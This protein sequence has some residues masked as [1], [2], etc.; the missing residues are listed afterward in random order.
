MEN[1]A[2]DSF[3]T[4]YDLVIPIEETDQ[5]ASSGPHDNANG[6]ED[7][8]SGMHDKSP[9][10]A[11]SMNLNQKRVQL[12]NTNREMPKTISAQKR[13]SLLGE[14]PDDAKY[15]PVSCLNSFT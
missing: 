2:K 10:A 3:P 5:H 14:D 8:I 4:N 11:T 15:M 6:A 12:P 1:L 7:Y 13:P 9:T